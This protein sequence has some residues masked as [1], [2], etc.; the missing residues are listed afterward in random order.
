MLVLANFGTA[1]EAENLRIALEN[2]GILAFVENANTSITLS[3]I[4]PALSGVRVVI[5]SDDLFA[6]QQILESLQKKTGE[7]WFCGPCQEVV[8]AGFEICW[9]C[10][11]PKE[12]AATD[13]P[14]GIEPP[15]PSKPETEEEPNTPLPPVSDNPFQSPS[16]GQR[17][18]SKR[19]L[20]RNPMV[21]LGSI[22]IVYLVIR[23]IMQ[24]I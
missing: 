10:G 24:L 23:A 16:E 12:E 3:Y 2:Q 7:A 19:Q 14:A 20:G 15:E 5:D 11:R 22:A 4:G 17:Q 13:F 6:A 18:S 1:A 9:S 8:D 21:Y